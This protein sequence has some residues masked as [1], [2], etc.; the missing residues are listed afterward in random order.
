MPLDE[1]ISCRAEKRLP[2]I[3]VVRLANLESNNG[4]ASEWTY[5]DNISVHGARIFTQRLWQPGE[6][7]TLTPFKE[8][9]ACGSV[10]YCQTAA[11]GRYWVGVKLKD[12]LIPWRAV[13]GT[14]G[15]QLPAPVSAT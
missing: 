4:H 14:D 11:H 6:E 3:V 12:H 13:K 8:E 10:I 9:T 5:T 15:I 7:I 2:I 1:T